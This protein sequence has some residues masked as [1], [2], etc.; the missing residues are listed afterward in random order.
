MKL[1]GASLAVV[2]MTA[3]YLLAM[4]SVPDTSLAILFSISVY[5][6]SVLSIIAFMNGGR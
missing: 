1:F 3:I 6:S 2:T 4:D 5:G